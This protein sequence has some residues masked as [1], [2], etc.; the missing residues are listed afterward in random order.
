VKY[1]N[2]LVLLAK[3]ETA[4]RGMTDRLLRRYYGIEVNVGKTM[5]MSISR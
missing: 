4:L 3:E 2:H 5:A 1:A